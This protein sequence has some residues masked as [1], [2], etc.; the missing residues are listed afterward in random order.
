MSDSL[1]VISY[2]W[3]EFGY[4]RKREKSGFGHLGL[5]DLKMELILRQI[6]KVKM[7]EH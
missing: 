5:T 1:R 6:V 4:D 2:S 7:A 3:K